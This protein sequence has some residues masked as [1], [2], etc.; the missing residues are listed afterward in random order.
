MVV[1]LIP[2][3]VYNDVPAAGKFVEL[4]TGVLP[5]TLRE[6]EL[7]VKLISMKYSVLADTD[8]PV[9]TVLAVVPSLVRRSQF[10]L[11]AES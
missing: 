2:A 4:E 3:R 10:P 6:T 11:V 8:T 9:L 7:P 5:F 1:G